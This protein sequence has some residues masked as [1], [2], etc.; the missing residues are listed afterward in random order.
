MKEKKNIDRLY[1]EKFKDFEASPPSHLWK[2]ISK[3]L[4]EEQK[5]I[6]LWYKL[7]GAA[8]VLALV[9]AGSWWASTNFKPSGTQVVFEID[10]DQKPQ[11]EF[12]GEKNELLKQSGSQ[13]QHIIDGNRENNSEKHSRIAENHGRK[14]EQDAENNTVEKE[15]TSKQ[16]HSA[17]AQNEQKENKEAKDSLKNITK[18]IEEGIA[19]NKPE[20]KTSA[21]NED[22]EDTTGL[23]L[24]EEDKEDN[25]PTDE[26]EF[27]TTRKNRLSLKTFAAPI[28]YNNMGN[29]SAIDPQFAQNPSSSNLSMAYGMNI[30]YAISE[31]VK[32]RSGIGKVSMNYDIQEVG[33][34]TSV[35]TQAISTINYNRESSN[36]QVM[37]TH[38]SDSYSS[39]NF[40]SNND[41][42]PEIIAS[43]TMTGELNQQFGYIEVPLEIEYKLIDK[44]IGLNIIGGGSSLFLDENAITLN[45][46]NQ[47][48]VLGEA[49]NLNKTSF[50]TNIG[51]G[52]D[53]NLG[54]NFGINL[55][56][57]FKYQINTF[58][59]AGDVQPFF[60]GVYSGIS[61][62]F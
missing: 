8:A 60:F 58:D 56:P 41:F 27:S 35:N 22:E 53:Y 45:A 6:P 23:A 29:G 15:N 49:N 13:L 36:L 43:R 38:S 7:A 50:S 12:P 39:P 17:I 57:I 1:Q 59:N 48:T 32:I 34:N 55:E 16:E 3:E 54:D 31:K 46:N 33:F 25:S 24:L 21:E 4:K 51:L 52:L 14:T 5:I 62:R 28:V 26:K 44:K 18:K 19:E 61:Y 9:L 37:S 10:E 47:S 2:N 40:P 42:S 20:D 30:A 11:F